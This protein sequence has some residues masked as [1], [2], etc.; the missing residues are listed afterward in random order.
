MSVVDMERERA[1]EICTVALAPRWSC[2][3]ADDGH[4]VA[5]VI[6]A[7]ALFTSTFVMIIAMHPCMSI[8][9]MVS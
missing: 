3:H 4:D 1:S 5:F 8:S 7:I 9:S 2:G 6:H